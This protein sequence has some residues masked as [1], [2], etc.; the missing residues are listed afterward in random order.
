MGRRS[1]LVVTGSRAEYGSQAGLVRMISED[2]GLEL[3]LVVTGSHLSVTHGFTVLEIEGDGVPISARVD[4]GQDGDGPDDVARAIATGVSGFSTVFHKM[5]PDMVVVF[6]DR[7]EMLCP[8]L[9]ALPMGVPLAHIAGGQLSEGTMDDAIRHSLTKLSHIH[10]TSTD[11]YAKRIVQLGEDPARVFVVGSTGIDSILNEPLLSRD[12]FEAA[13]GI[14]LKHPS[15]M[16]TFHPATFDEVQP[17]QQLEEFLAVLDARPDL[18]IIFTMPN[19]D[20]NNRAIREGIMTYVHK[21]SDR[22]SAHESLGRQLYHTALSIV[23]GV[24]GNSSSGL[25]EAPSFRI[26]T[27]NIGD[28]QRGRIRPGSVID[29]GAERGAIGVAIDRILSSEFRDSIQNMAN[30]FGDGHASKRI[31]EIMCSYPLEGLTSKRFYDVEFD[32]ENNGYN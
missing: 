12:E 21:N 4:L 13:T 26:G 23:D 24:V 30:P 32:F 17:R 3:Q 8:A 1:I 22:A 9:A 27:V 19:T 14:V 18:Q 5:K 29:C 10:F 20:P 7:F 11:T 28:R 2:P 6:G 31:F 16:A 25:I 15:L